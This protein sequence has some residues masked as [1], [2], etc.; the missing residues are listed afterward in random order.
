MQRARSTRTQYRFDIGNLEIEIV[1]ETE[2]EQDLPSLEVPEMCLVANQLDELIL[3]LLEVRR[4][5]KT[6]G[7]ATGNPSKPKPSVA[8]VLTPR[9]GV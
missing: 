4:D 2:T 6:R 5:M 1:H 3:A 9:I 7:H 8:K